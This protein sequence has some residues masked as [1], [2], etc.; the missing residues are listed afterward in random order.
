[1]QEAY[2]KVSTSF[3]VLK[4][5]A[6]YAN[7][8]RRTFDHIYMLLL[9]KYIVS[10]FP[11]LVHSSAS[12]SKQRVLRALCFALHLNPNGFSTILLVAVLS[13][14]RYILL[15][16]P[17]CGL[18]TSATSQRCTS[19]PRFVSVCNLI[20]PSDNILVLSCRLMAGSH[21][22]ASPPLPQLRDPLT[23]NA[24]AFHWLRSL[25]RGLSVSFSTI[26]RKT[27]LS[28]LFLAK[29]SDDNGKL[30]H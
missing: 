14:D 12:G 2:N 5:S 4:G 6:T 18:F 11:P 27:Y 17:V 3:S 25:D 20:S 15:L 24:V 22:F 21:S 29:E 26:Y 30:L 19:L 13:V 1:M 8:R 7:S 9:R 28:G 16:A 23:S 10:C